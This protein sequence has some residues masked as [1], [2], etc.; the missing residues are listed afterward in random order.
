MNFGMVG[1]SIKRNNW[2]HVAIVAAALVAGLIVGYT[3]KQNT[4]QAQTAVNVDARTCSMGKATLS[5]E[6]C[7]Q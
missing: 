3:V 1:S 5:G 7:V 4:A 2:I 6:A